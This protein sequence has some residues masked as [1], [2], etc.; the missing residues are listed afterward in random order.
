MGRYAKAPAPVEASPKRWMALVFLCGA[1]AAVLADNPLV[2]T[3]VPTDIASQ[4][5]WMTNAYAV[6]FVAAVIPAGALADRYGRRRLLVSSLI[7]LAVLSI[8]TSRISNPYHLVPWRLLAGTAAAGVFPATLSIIGD[9]FRDDRERRI[10][11]GAWV[12]ATG[13][14]LAAGPLAAAAVTGPTWTWSIQAVA[15]VSLVC[16]AGSA[17]FVRE[18]KDPL[19]FL[20]PVGMLLA[21]VAAIF[22]VVALVGLQEDG[23]TSA[24][25]ATLALGL[26]GLVGFVKWESNH[27]EPMVD[28]AVFRSRDLRGG[29]IAAAAAQVT[30]FAFIVL[31][32]Q[33]V[34]YVLDYSMVDIVEAMIP[35][36]VACVVGVVVGVTALASY[37][38]RFVVAGGLVMST[39]GLFWASGLETGSRW[40]AVT[41]PLVLLGAGMGAACAPATNLI[42]GALP[43]SST[44][45]GF[46]VNGLTR[47][48]G[49]SLGAAVAS[50]VTAASY[51][52]RVRS[53]FAGTLMPDFGVEAAA[54]NIHMGIQAAD[55]TGVVVSSEAA[56][57]IRL[58]V[59]ESF[60]ESLGSGL[61]VASLI[62]VWAVVAVVWLIPAWGENVGGVKSRRGRRERIATPPTVEEPLGETTGP[63]PESVHPDR[64]R[65]AAIASASQPQRRPERHPPRRPPRPG[66]SRPEPLDPAAAA[67]ARPR[68]APKLP[69]DERIPA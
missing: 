66:D 28:L 63:E 51:P 24:V 15:A 53:G 5:T 23:F 49:A 41:A 22:A 17:A 43:D 19:R 13:I 39:T 11:L 33:H 26:C 40:L 48:L 3:V 30:T 9:L 29:L 14:G 7:S 69:T 55:T 20:D 8:L 16:A 37:G 68:P 32:F 2:S 21:S 25:A 35:F 54:E 44:G 58:M 46:A 52:D 50:A 38:Y 12:S 61:R 6:A 4:T 60:S 47:Q 59:R 42:L 65:P 31:G 57:A 56:D 18:S 34:R 10:A 36:A 27:D 45:G 67:R 64:T 1:I 62:G